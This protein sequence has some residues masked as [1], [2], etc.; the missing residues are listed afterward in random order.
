M[1]ET[2]KD[3]D[4]Y[5]GVLLREKITWNDMFDLDLYPEA[6][7]DKRVVELW[8]KNRDLELCSL[9][10]Q[11]MSKYFTELG[12]GSV[13]ADD[14]EETWSVLFVDWVKP[15]TP[16]YIEF[17]EWGERIGQEHVFVLE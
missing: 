5:V 4:G 7:F 1:V 6:R 10:F 2:Y 8:L 13:Y 15:N 14:L 11:E 16:F 12:Y 9:D 3:E 17:T